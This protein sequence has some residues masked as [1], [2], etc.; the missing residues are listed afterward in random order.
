MI[1][2]GSDQGR[3][4]P[5]APLDPFVRA[6]EAHAAAR[7]RAPVLHWSGGVCTRADLL[8]RARVA[9]ETL[10]RAGVGSGTVVALCAA[11][12]PAFLAAWLALRAR[13]ACVLALEP[14]T[15]AEERERCL[16][17]LG[18]EL[19]WEVG[20]EFQGQGRGLRPSGAPSAAQLPGVAALLLTSGSSGAP[21]AV[22]LGADA[23]AADGRQ[24]A[25]TMGLRGDDR[26]LSVLPWSHSYGFSLLP[27]SALLLGSTLVL[28]GEE[29]PREAAERA[30]ATVL[31]SVPSW[32]RVQLAL[33]GER[34]WPRSLRLFLSA[35]AVL[36]PAVA[37]AWR[38]HT[39][40][41]IHVFYGSSEAGGI[42]FDRRGDAGERGTVGTPVD[43]VQVELAPEAEPG[44]GGT[45]RAR[46]AAVA[47]GYH[48]SPAGGSPSDP[49]GR[50]GEG[51]FETED[52]A[53]WEDGELRLLGRRS[54]WINVKG[55]K[56]DPREVERTIA[57]LPGVDEVIVIPRELPGGRGQSV[58]AVIASSAGA[59]TYEQVIDWCRGKLAPHKVPRAV[60]VVRE[61]PRTER[62]K[63]DRRALAAL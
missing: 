16:A 56:V 27:T 51:V 38:A 44:R 62:G 52:L 22:A 32:F 5:T 6:F 17:A 36:P 25:S 11:P 13:E 43:G 59:V 54:E 60:T 47:L 48:P 57:A 35:G 61:L 63:V 2:S 18:A 53:R 26:L 4:R 58:R 21:R 29:D 30:A 3:I 50:L 40:R 8:A 39:G 9:G 33:R 23:L 55:H 42:T 20:P 12:G 45:V 24:L 41:P 34:P 1:S 7:P 49:A 46:S 19:V 10:D 31:P 37:R 28:P 14:S 15:A